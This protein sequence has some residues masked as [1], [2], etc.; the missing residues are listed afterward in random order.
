MKEGEWNRLTIMAQGST[1][2]TWINGVAA[3]HWINDEYLQGFFGLQVHA[4]T[5]GTVLWKNIRVKE[6]PK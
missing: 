5:K 1:V 6:F 3:A 4:G 2:K